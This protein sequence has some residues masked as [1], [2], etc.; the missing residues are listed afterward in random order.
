MSTDLILKPPMSENIS[1]FIDHHSKELVRSIPS[2][3]DDTPHFLREIEDFMKSSGFIGDNVVP[4]SIDLT[5]LY[6]NIPTDEGLLAID[7]ALDTRTIREVSTAFLI[8]L[9]QL[10]I[11]GNVVEFNMKN[12]VRFDR[13]VAG[14][15]II[16]VEIF[17]VKVMATVKQP[18]LFTEALDSPISILVDMGLVYCF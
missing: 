13:V 4:V 1:K 7:V 3:L 8:S 5:G 16:D 6:P 9:L 15:S 11:T 2:H 17:Q 18:S 14:H 12:K 10:V